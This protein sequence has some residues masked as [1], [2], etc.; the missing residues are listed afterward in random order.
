MAVVILLRVPAI[1]SKCRKQV[2]QMFEVLSFAIR[3]GL[4]I[5]LDAAKF[6][7]LSVLIRIEIICTKI[8]AK[9]LPKIDCKM[10]TS[11]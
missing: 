5:C 6:V 9:S 10:S 1:I 7:L 2:Y 11:R 4:L 3:K 8:C